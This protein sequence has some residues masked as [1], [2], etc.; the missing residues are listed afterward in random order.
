MKIHSIRVRNYIISLFA[1]SALTLIFSACGGGGGGG[2]PTPSGP[3]AGPPV[4]AFYSNG[5]DWNDYIVNSGSTQFDATNTACNAATDGPGYSACLHGGEI[6]AMEITGYRSCTGL[7]ATD[8]LG[9]FDWTCVVTA[10]VNMVSTGLKDG[11]YL[12]DLIDFSGTPS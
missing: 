7:T 2:S 6:R 5:A 1:V 3:A 10:T 12:S 11:K 8:A 4:G 9:A